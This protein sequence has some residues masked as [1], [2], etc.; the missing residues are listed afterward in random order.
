MRTC[1]WIGALALIG[2]FTCSV[3]AQSRRR[4]ATQPTTKEQEKPTAE[5]EY[6]SAGSFSITQG[7][8]DI[9]GQTL[10]YEATAGQMALNDDSGKRKANVFIVAYV[11][12]PTDD[13]D[14]RPITFVFNGGPGAAAVWLHMGT[15]GPRH[16]EMN[17]HGDP[18]TPPYHVVD[19]PDTWLASTDLVFID[20]V[21]TGF[22]RAANGE[23]PEQFYGVQ[24]DIRSVAEVIRL[25]ITQHNRWISPKFLAGESYG[26]TR[27]AG[28]SSYL[29]EQD[30]IALNGIV[31]I[32]SVLDFQTL[33]FSR[34]ND[35]PYALYLPSY[36]AIAHYYKK[37]V[38]DLQNADLSQTLKEV[39]Q[40]ATHD[41]LDALAAGRSLTADQRDAVAKKLS[42]Y[43]G[44]SLDV[45]LKANLRINAGAFRAE[46]LADKQEIIGRFDARIAG[47]NPDPLT[48]SDE[49]DPSLAPYLA[50]YT[51]AFEW[52]SRTALKYKD[53]HE[54]DALS[55]K[56]G[57]WNFG[58]GSG[59]LDVATSLQDAMMKSPH[60]K[61]MFC[62]GL[63]DLATPYLTADYTIWHMNLS[64]DLRANI[65]HNYY[66]GGHMLYH[67]Q[68]SRQK[69]GQDIAAFIRSAM[70]AMT[71]KAEES[72]T[73][74]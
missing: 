40:W 10:K 44:L 47:Y 42:R 20:P 26:T 41:Y 38:P 30:G 33:D 6:D 9:H 53:D 52:Y 27:A 59:Y 54:F 65:S 49:Y 71:G 39:Q 69:L 12:Q 17:D 35:L 55:S 36:S 11:K 56:V 14:T 3:M 21:G 73:S 72:G 51:G 4:P 16:I 2:I 5:R 22:S 48:M 67:Y 45:V 66:E 7:S 24:E 50:A 23:K 68:P 29:L 19:N 13:I 8:I 25:Y 37:L 74:K 18:P 63:S 58:R 62:N 31:L 64:P 28:L 61:V 60:M 43:T 1:R 46:L 70:P 32:S 57:P 34:G 15:A